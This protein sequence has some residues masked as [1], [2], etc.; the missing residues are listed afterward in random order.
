M[1]AQAPLSVDAYLEALP[2]AQRPLLVKI[3]AAIKSAAPKAEEVI[4]YQMPAYKYHGMLVY[5]AAFKDH[6]SLFPAS[7]RVITVFADELKAFKTFGGTIQFST[8]HPLPIKL[9]KQIVQYRVKENEEKKAMK[10]A[11]KKAPR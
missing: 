8:E 4:S 11:G 10:Q 1:K 9:L 6:C 5:F 7:K 2:A 3:R